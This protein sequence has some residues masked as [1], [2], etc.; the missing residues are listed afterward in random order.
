MIKAVFLSVVSRMCISKLSD[1]LE[2][3]APCLE[4]KFE[5]PYFLKKKGT[6]QTKSL[7]R[8]IWCNTTYR[9]ILFT[10]DG[11]RH[12]GLK[13]WYSGNKVDISYM[14][15]LRSDIVLE[16]LR[17]AK[18]TQSYSSS[19]LRREKAPSWWPMLGWNASWW[20]K[21]SSGQ[22]W[23]L[24]SQWSFF[25][26]LSPSSLHHHQPIQVVWGNLKYSSIVF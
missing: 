22:R 8:L 14:W 4:L 1:W 10:S 18:N 7:S 16:T 17:D 3:L 20:S 9:D 24:W 19:T 5:R 12:A 15:E 2:I 23:L 21:W 25:L 13:K 11:F 6:P 26:L